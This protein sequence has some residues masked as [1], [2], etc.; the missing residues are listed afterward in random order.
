MRALRRFFLKKKLADASGAVCPDKI[1]VKYYSSKAAKDIL[2]EL[3]GKGAF[4]VS[5]IADRELCQKELRCSFK[6][7]DGTQRQ[8]FKPDNKLCLF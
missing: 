1:R 6:L 8:G 4:L 7:F 2:E 3:L 5:G